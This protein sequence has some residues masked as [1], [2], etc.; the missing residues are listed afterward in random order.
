MRLFSSG[1]RN[2]A[3]RLL[4]TR[5][6]RFANRVTG[7][8]AGARL[9]E[10]DAGACIV[11]PDDVLTDRLVASIARQSRDPE[12]GLVAVDP[13]IPELER[14]LRAYSAAVQQSGIA[15]RIG[16]AQTIQVAQTKVLDH[17]F[18]LRNRHVV[19]FQPIVEL[20][21]GRAH[22][23]ECLLR[24][25][26]PT[27]PTSI[28]A[29]V[30][31]AIDTDRSV[32]LDAYIVGRILARATE[33]AAERS[34]RGD[35]PLR[36]AINLTPASLLADEFE[37]DTL[38]AVVHH[39]GLPPTQITLECTE[40][41]SVSDIEPLRRRVKAMRRLGFGFAVDDAGAGYASFTLIAGLR[42]SLIKIDRE[43]V[44]GVS[45]DDA[46]QAL[47]ESFVSFGRRIGAR[48][49]AEGIER[50]RDL[51]TL[52]SL[53]VEYGQGYLLGKPAAS[54][55]PAR[56]IETMAEAAVRETAAAAR[57]LPRRQVSDAVRSIRD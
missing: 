50:R 47:V 48:L 1:R 5:D 36:L 7:A 38:A 37:A 28:G 34:A 29:I 31:A 16:M 14:Y 3:E 32:E 53:G 10:L 9:L 39:A 2:D 4:W 33:L 43:I 56:R 42:P 54:P 40:Q 51:A 21:T 41:Q 19:H 46:K 55:E 35:E 8:A 30:Q 23:Y 11:A 52:S 22:E 15:D 13:A 24:P 25:D 20:T 44:H 6:T 45:T 27:L 49:V 26:M 17:F 18:A 12:F 57:S